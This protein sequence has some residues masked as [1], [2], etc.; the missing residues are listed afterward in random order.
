MKSNK[1]IYFFA[2]LELDNIH[3]DMDY[4]MMFDQN[5]DQPILLFLWLT[6]P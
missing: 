3:H 6:V 2:L 5:P 1:N 4:D